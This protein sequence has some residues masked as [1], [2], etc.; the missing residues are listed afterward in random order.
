MTVTGDQ[1]SLIQQRLAGA[2]RATARA[3]TTI[4]VTDPGVPAP[5]S[6]AQ[7]RLWFMHQLEPSSA[8]YHVTATVRLAGPLDVAALTAAIRDLTARHHV[9]RSRFADHDGA[10]VAD[11]GGQRGH[12]ERTGEPHGRGH[13]VRGAGRLQLV[14]EPQPGL[15][16]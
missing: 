9:L 8:A 13:V 12:V 7:A 15:R 11:R 16:R 2:R 4:P 6:P 10:P 1:R 3:A 14:H 5:L